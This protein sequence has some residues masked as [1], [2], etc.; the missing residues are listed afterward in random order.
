LEQQTA[1]GS[2][3]RAIAASPTDIQPVL[4]A[5]CESAARLCDAY[6][7]VILLQD[8]DALTGKAHHGPIPMEVNKWPI[9]RTWV[10][11]RAFLERKPLQVEDVRQVA[12]EYPVSHAAGSRSGQRTVLA[13]PLVREDEA[14][15]VL[16]IRRIEVRPFAQKQID[17][18]TTFADQAVIAIENVRLF[19]EVQK[20]TAELARSVDELRALGEVSQAVN[21]TLDLKTVLETIVA[22]AVQ[23]SQTDAGAIYVYSKATQKFRLRAT[24]HERGIIAA[25]SS[26]AVGLKTRGRRGRTDARA[27][28]DARS[29]PG[30][31]YVHQV[32]LDAGYRG[33]FVV[34]LLR[35]I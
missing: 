11:G 20:R 35:P 31:S 28:T 16:V 9:A 17:L 13:M 23:L 10:A 19:D 21:S 4:D 22:K 15:G 2:I 14:V 7:T 1:T 34:P 29:Q 3:L 5:V 32:V 24:G 25:I 33:V 18:L 6:D 8:G 27:G 30:I 12:E 26:H